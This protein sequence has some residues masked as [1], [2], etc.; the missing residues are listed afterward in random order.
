MSAAPHHGH[1][2]A[3]RRLVGNE[4][5]DDDEEVDLEEEADEEEAFEDNV[6]DVMKC[7]CWLQGGATQG[8]DAVELDTIPRVDNTGR[9]GR[10]ADVCGRS[11]CP[12]FAERA[13]KDSSS[14]T[15]DDAAEG[16][17]EV[18]GEGKEGI[19]TFSPVIGEWPMLEWWIAWWR[20][21]S[22]MWLKRR[23]QGG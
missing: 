5:V 12:S 4:A 15:W 18:G 11:S 14:L 10:C 16:M 19:G 9:R 6:D 7:A 22:E 3:L 20:S 1:L 13:R 8:N 2:I 17:V 23:G 21:S